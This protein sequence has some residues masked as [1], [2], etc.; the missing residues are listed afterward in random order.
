MFIITQL[1]QVFELKKIPHGG[2]VIFFYNYTRE[3]V[4]NNLVINKHNI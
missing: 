3:K 2:D 1:V 4:I